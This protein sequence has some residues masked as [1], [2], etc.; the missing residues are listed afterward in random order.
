MKIF[1]DTA[2]VKEIK[3]ARELGV[4]DGVTTNPSL[5]AKE[6]RKAHD[7]LKEICSLVDGPVSAEAISL[8]LE[9]MVGEAEGLSKIAK[10]IVVK[11]PLTKEGLK[12]VKA[13]SE[14]GIRTNVT[15]CFSPSQALL[16]AKAGADYISPFIGR[17]DDISQRGMDLIKSIKTIY[18]NY[19]FK[20]KIIVASIRNPLHVVDAALTGA[21]IATVPFTVIEQLIRHPLTDIGIHRIMEDYKR[22]PKK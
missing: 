17:L 8:D 4:I 14:K 10:N 12:A 6:N 15:L 16:V 18:N 7:L 21:D 22:I 11:I 5:I 1:I 2:N 19:G 3:E 9:G 13:L 20:T